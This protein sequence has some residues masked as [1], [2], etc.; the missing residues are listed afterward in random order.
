MTGGSSADLLAGGDGDDTLLGNSGSDRLYG[1]EGDD[2]LNGG[3]S[4]DTLRGGSGADTLNGGSGTDVVD[5]Y[6]SASVSVNLATSVVSGGDAQGDR[7]IG[8]ERVYGSNE[9]DQ[10]TGTNGSNLLW[11]RS[12]DDTIKGGSGNDILRGGIGADLLNGE[13]GTDT[14]DYLGSVLGVTVNLLTGVHRN[15]DAEGDILMD[16]ERVYGSN[17]GDHLTGNTFSNL[18]W[19]RDGND[20]INGGSGND[21]I[22]SGLG[23]DILNGDSGLDAADYLT[24]PVSVTVNLLTGVNQGGDAQGDQLTNFE[25]VYGSDFDDQISGDSL[26]NSLWGRDGDDTIHGAA[27][28]DTIRSGPGRDSLDGGDG[29]DTLDYV[30]SNSAVTVDLE[31]EIL[32]GGDATGDIAINFERVYGSN[33]NDQISGDALGNLLLGRSGRDTLF[34]AEGNDILRGGSGADS[35]NGG[36]G[37]D[38]LDYFGS[39]AGVTVNLSTGIVNGGDAQGDTIANFE[40]AYGSNV[41]DQLTGDASGNLLFG[42]SGRD[43]LMGG[44]GRDTLLGGNGSDQFLIAHLNESLLSSSD[45]IKDF[46]IGV[47]SLNALT[48]V[49][50]SHLPQLGR[51]ATLNSAGIQ[52]VLTETDFMAQGAA[53]FTFEDRTYI[54]LNDGVAGFQSSQDSIINITGYSGNLT[55]LSVV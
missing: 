55:N 36:L 22:R 45:W 38:I 35:L 37:A 16:F 12:G 19:G 42:R 20:T 18:I 50:S 54:A 21:I 49:S 23:A 39:T 32:Q 15:G 7:L 11:G 51:V 6:G 33:F 31:A 13:S 43:T 25:R 52:A 4:N 14:V 46:D 3:A 44:L 41:D 34:G 10:I 17:E 27:G 28:N 29:L 8:L 53:T 1:E 40:R 24:S 5:Y 26:A 30:A 2:S 47:D 48:A 9:G